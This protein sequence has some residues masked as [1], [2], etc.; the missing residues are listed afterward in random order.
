[1]QV[2]PIHVPR[3]GVDGRLVV[4]H[5]VGDPGCHVYV[6]EVDPAVTL[7]DDGCV[8]VGYASGAGVRRVGVSDS[9]AQRDAG[10]DAGECGARRVVGSLQVTPTCVMVLLAATKLCQPLVARPQYGAPP[11][12]RL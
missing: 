6:A 10:G 11:D 3:P 8:P 12:M 9:L 7:V 1:V 2:P 5:V 4:E